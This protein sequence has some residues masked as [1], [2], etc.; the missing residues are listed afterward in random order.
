MLQNGAVGLR[1]Y[2]RDGKGMH[3]FGYIHM[4]V[5]HMCVCAFMAARQ[6]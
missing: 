6:I 1:V 2:M 3:V 4:G 5:L